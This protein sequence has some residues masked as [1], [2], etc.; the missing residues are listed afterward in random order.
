M[1]DVIDRRREELNLPVDKSIDTSQYREAYADLMRT[2]KST[3]ATGLTYLGFLSKMHKRNLD[4]KK[5]EHNRRVVIL[6]KK[7]E[8]NAYEAFINLKSKGNADAN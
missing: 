1:I 2:S 3:R 7:R 8:P 5:Q 4:R 6:D